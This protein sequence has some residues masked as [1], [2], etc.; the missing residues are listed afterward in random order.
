VSELTLRASDFKQ[1]PGW[2]ECCGDVDVSA[3]D[4]GTS[5]CPDCALV[6]GW[7]DEEQHGLIETVTD[8]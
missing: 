6:E 3:S 8:A 5:W 4:G 1:R 2:C 7:L